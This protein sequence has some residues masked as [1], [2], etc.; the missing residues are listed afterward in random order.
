MVCISSPPSLSL[1]LPLQ[2][3]TLSEQLSVAVE[4][5]AQKLENYKVRYIQ[6]P[7]GCS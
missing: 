3:T 7:P 4:S 1:S 6:L 2:Q 5:Q